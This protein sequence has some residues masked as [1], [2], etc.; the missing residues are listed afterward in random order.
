M[1]KTLQQKKFEALIEKLPKS[2]NEFS[3]EQLLQLING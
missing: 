2:L 1:A 3:V